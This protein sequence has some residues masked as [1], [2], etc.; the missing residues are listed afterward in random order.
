MSRVKYKILIK[1]ANKSIFPRR[2]LSLCFTYMPV[3][4]SHYY[5]LRKTFYLNWNCPSGNVYE[6]REMSENRPSFNRN[7][8][9]LSPR[10]NV[11]NVKITKNFHFSFHFLSYPFT[12][13]QGDHLPTPPPIPPGEFQEF[14]IIFYDR[15]QELTRKFYIV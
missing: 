5:C 9:T 10:R 1:R 2:V 14:Y 3:N 12:C 13:P 11:V 15:F 6:R 4:H 8:L 7:S